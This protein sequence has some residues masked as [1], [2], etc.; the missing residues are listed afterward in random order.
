[1]KMKLQPNQ[2]TLP[3]R[4]F[5]NINRVEPSL[6]DSTAV[7]TF[8][9]CPRKYFYRMVLGYD[10]T[11]KQPYFAFGTAY[12]RF[13]EVLELKFNEGIPLDMCI[14][15]ALDVAAAYC[16]KH[17]VTPTDPKSKWQFMTK[18]RLI[19]SCLEGAKHW[20]AEKNAKNI[21]V[22]AVEQAF[23]IELPNGKI[24]AGRADQMIKFNGKVW[25]RDFKTSSQQGNWYVKSLNPNHQFSLYCYAE[26]KL[27]G[28]NENDLNDK[29][30]VE[31]QLIEVLYNAKTVG[32]KI[33]IYP[34]NRTRT[35]LLS[36]L[37]EEQQWHKM[38]DMC[39]EDDIWPMNPKSCW[40]CEFRDVCELSSESA[41]Q[42][43]LKN[44]YRLAPWDC[45]LSEQ[46]GE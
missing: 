29:I 27:A 11:V 33:D 38:M 20:K 22:I 14:V 39:R 10:T 36:W 5:P 32:P 42:S 31:G 13:R 28:W 37:K 34:A 21:T 40:S 6:M 17:L 18:Q 1:M 30:K 46:V 44:K 9:T 25:G 4:K 15:D 2:S 8:L 16:D 26:N 41:Q 24:I 23:Q 43:M 3:T 7:T 35:D 19:Q 12:H 45:T